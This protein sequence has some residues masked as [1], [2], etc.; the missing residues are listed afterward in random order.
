MK[1]ILVIMFLLIP[2]VSFAADNCETITVAATAIGFTSGNI[3]RGNFEAREALCI[4]QSGQIRYWTDGTDPTSTTGIV[5]E[6]GQALYLDKRG[7]ITKF[8]AIRTGSTSGVLSCC[9]N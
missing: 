8:K 6:I 7:D 2:I 4:N 5:L 3:S 9:Y 1:T